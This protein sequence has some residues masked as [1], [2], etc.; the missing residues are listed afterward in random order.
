MTI[1]K[2]EFCIHEALKTLS[3]LAKIILHFIQIYF[4][5]VWMKRRVIEM[6]SKDILITGRFILMFSEKVRKASMD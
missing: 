3:H 4:E 6:Y 1:V 2:G 5:G